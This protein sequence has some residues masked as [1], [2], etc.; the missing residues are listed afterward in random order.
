MQKKRNPLVLWIIALV[1][2]ALVLTDMLPMFAQARE[3]QLTAVP[4]IRLAAAEPAPAA[5]PP[6]L[7]A[8]QQRPRKRKPLMD[9]LF[10]GGAEPQEEAPVIEEPVV[11]A[12]KADLPPAKPKIPKADTAVRLAVFGDS[13][14]IDI[15]KALERLYAEDPN[16]AII[17]QGVGDSG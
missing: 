11:K 6:R 14:A 2:G 5:P 9:L 15:A 1:V 8:Q 12:P 16:I 13:I 3:L 4:D 17:N 7:V 10:G